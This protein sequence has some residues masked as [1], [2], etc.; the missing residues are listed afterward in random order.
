MATRLIV[1]GPLVVTAH[2]HCQGLLDCLGSRVCPG[3]SPSIMDRTR[4]RHRW[5]GWAYPG[6]WENGVEGT[7]QLAPV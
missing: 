4:N 5:T 1:L 6:A 3:N 7:R 2:N